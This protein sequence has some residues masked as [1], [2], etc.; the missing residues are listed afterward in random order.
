[1]SADYVVLRT[2]DTVY[3]R[4]LFLKAAA[5][6]LSDRDTRAE[7]DAALRSSGGQAKLSVMPQDVSGALAVLHET[8][9]PSY[10]HQV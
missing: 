2:Q 10:S 6:C 9:E 8:G 7:Y 4:A 3:S 5:E 1:M